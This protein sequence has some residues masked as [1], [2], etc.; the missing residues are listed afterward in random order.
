MKAS[1]EVFKN[2]K[3]IGEWYKIET[4]LTI[5]EIILACKAKFGIKGKYTINDFG[6][7]LRMVKNYKKKPGIWIDIYLEYGI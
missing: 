5:P 4:N 2:Q 1:I 3:S 7:Q 6:T